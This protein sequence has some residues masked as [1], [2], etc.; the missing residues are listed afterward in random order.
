MA[1]SQALL[2]PARKRN[3]ASLFGLIFFASIITV[4]ASELLPCPAHVHK[5]RFADGKETGAKRDTVTVVEKR[6][7][8]W[9]EEKR[10]N[11]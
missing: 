1:L 10:P 7:R 11:S 6:P 4:S 9:I 5:G 3:L 2:V 8:R